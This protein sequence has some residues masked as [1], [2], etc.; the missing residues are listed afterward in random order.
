M[1]IANMKA[2]QNFTIIHL[3]PCYRQYSTPSMWPLKRQHFNNENIIHQTDLD[4]KYIKLMCQ[5]DYF[6][7]VH[8]VLYL[9]EI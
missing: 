1:C 4:L 7:S 9:I 5:T 3:S 6:L 2:N 8:N